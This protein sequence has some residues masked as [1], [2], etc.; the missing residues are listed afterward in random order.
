MTDD[1]DAQRQLADIAS[2]A[3]THDR[4][5]ANRVDDSV[6]EIMD[7]APRCCAGRAAMRQQ[8]VALAKS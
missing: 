5:I 3:L 7:D 6:V 1:A 8:P 2:F 4:A